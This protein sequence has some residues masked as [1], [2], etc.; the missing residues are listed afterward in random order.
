MEPDHEFHEIRPGICKECNQ[1]N[2]YRNWCNS[3]NA[4]HFQ[5]QSVNWTSG[6]PD[7][8]EFILQAQIGA[9]DHF[10]VIEWI[11]YEKFSNIKYLSKGGYGEVYFAIWDEGMITNWSVEYMDWWRDSSKSVILKSLFD[12]TNK[13][14]E[15]IDELRLQ[16]RSFETSITLGITPCFGITRNPKDGNFMMVME[17]APEGCLRKYLDKKFNKLIWHKK[18]DILCDIIRGIRSI[19]RAGLTHRDL[20]GGNIVMYT[21]YTRIT[22]FGLSK[23]VEVSSSKKN[24]KIFGVLP[25]VA[26]EV[27]CGEDYNPSADIYSF[28][29]IMNEM[30]TGI[31]PF[32]DVPHDHA[33]VLK[34]ISGIRPKIR[35]DLTPQ[36]IIDLI[37][38]CWDE[39]PDKRPT[40]EV[41][42][43]ILFK[44]KED[45]IVYTT[46]LY[47]QIKIIEKF[48]E[49]NGIPVDKESPITYETHPQAVYTSR[50]LEVN[51]TPAKNIMDSGMMDLV[52]PDDSD[53]DC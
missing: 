31:P 10:K 39:V 1:T 29:I 16:V 20:H 51:R 12:S 53:D 47:K 28:G 19:H 30:A 48:I 43:E 14:K 8:D 52:V 22:D 45:S 49:E 44:L 5:E 36:L 23:M 26:P 35:K 11:P 50:P 3:C 38:Q 40:A 37:D 42:Y 13:T 4:K 7:V 17:Y 18:L 41:L 9:K 15:F 27:L 6:N 25:F 33:L 24:N 2:T 32:N 34:I 46:E 21:N